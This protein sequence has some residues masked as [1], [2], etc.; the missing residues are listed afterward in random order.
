MPMKHDLKIVA[1]LNIW[2]IK[3]KKSWTGVELHNH[4]NNV[5]PFILIS[6]EYLP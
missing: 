1:H 3:I 4:D 6:R 5:L 2:V